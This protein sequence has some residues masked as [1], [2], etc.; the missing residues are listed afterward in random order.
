VSKLKS[1]ALS[2]LAQTWIILGIPVLFIIGS[3]MHFAYDWSGESTI[4]GIFTPVN[5]SIWEHLKMTFWPMLIWWFIGYFI[6]NKRITISV[7]QWFVS[8]SVAEIVCLLVIVSFYYT[9]TGAFGI[10]SLILDIFSLFLGIALGQ[11]IAL[12]I[13]KYGKNSNYFFQYAIAILVLMAL[14]FTIFTFYPPQIPLF[15]D[16]T[17]GEYGI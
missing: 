16:S 7:H 4:V 14:A 8:C 17:T 12:H 9:Y 2:R 13:Y 6:L 10:E 11:L 3:L 15:M 5:E 1:F